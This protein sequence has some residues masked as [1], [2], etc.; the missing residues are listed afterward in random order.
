MSQSPD[1]KRPKAQP[2]EKKAIP[3]RGLFGR[4]CAKP[5]QIG[6]PARALFGRRVVEAA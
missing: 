4:R 2:P 6:E 5:V 3:A 1:P